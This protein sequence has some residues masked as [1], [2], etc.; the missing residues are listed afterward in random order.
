MVA[1]C[2]IG[3]VCGVLIGQNAPLQT[4]MLRGFLIGGT[5]GLTAWWG[6]FTGMPGTHLRPHNIFYENHVTKEE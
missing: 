2:L 6:S 4:A 5:L 3:T 1:C